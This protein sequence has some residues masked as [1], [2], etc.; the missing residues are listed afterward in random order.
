MAEYRDEMHAALAEALG[1]SVEDFEAKL[2]SGETVW[3][4]AEAQGVSA[5][6]L[7]AAM[8]A[9]R[10]DILKQAVA[11]GVLTQEQADAMLSHMSARGGWGMMGRGMMGRGNGQRGGLGGNCPFANE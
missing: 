6:T 8:Q 7:Q 10:A 5:E 2:A 9:A 11:D 1:L 3:Q 4:I